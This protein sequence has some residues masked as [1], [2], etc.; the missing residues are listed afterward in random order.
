MKNLLNKEFKKHVATVHCS[1]SLS[2]LQRK[3][4]N[5]LLYYAY[6]DLAIKETH[7]ISIKELCRLIGTSTHNYDALKQA[8]KGLIATVIEW[9]IVD[10]FSK[11]E[12]WS[13][14][15]ILASVRIKS[16]ICSYSYSAKMRELLSCPTM[17]A[18]INL[19]M[20]SKFNSNYGLAL[21]ENCVRY[22]SLPCTKWFDMDLF[23]KLMGI[24]EGKYLIF[25]DLKRRVLDKAVFEVNTYSD[26]YIE[27]EMIKNGRKII[28]IRFKIEERI[29][30]GPLGERFNTEHS[31]FVEKL[32][33]LYNFSKSYAQRILKE[34]GFETVK[35]KSD[36]VQQSMTE[37]KQIDNPAGYLLNMLKFCYDAKE[38]RTIIGK[39]KNKT[40]ENTDYDSLR[41]E[42]REKIFCKYAKCE[43]EEQ[44]RI[45]SDFALF[46]G[47][48][49]YLTVFRR[50]GLNN[51]LVADE[52][53]R[54]IK[55]NKPN[56]V[57]T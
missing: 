41:N 31:E 53:V 43:V 17:Y 20:Q 49:V 35:A 46:L 3:I 50:E 29:K 39:E 24:G 9:N 28:K 34:Y 23:R 25:R 19:D 5:A 2:L 51:I 38:Y 57:L 30:K 48:S 18:K 7:Q 26:L 22:R 16:A 45:L 42:L 13:A 33:E 55:E 44:E 36:F 27:P 11:E 32:V 56:F 54:Y 1:G 8:L 12:D 40:F 21:Y 4:S 14:S 10:E 15:S 6:H 52:F 47:K 37:E